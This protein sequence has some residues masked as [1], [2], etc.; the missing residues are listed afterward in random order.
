[1]TRGDRAA[2][3]ALP[4][5][6]APVLLGACSTEIDPSAST[7]GGGS[8]TSTTVFVAEGTTAE[9]LDQLLAD[10]SGLSERIVENEGDEALLARINTIWDAARPGVEA[11]APDLMLEFDR[12]MV[13]V[14]SAVERRR[15]ADADKALNNLRNLVAALPILD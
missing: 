7:L 9:L 4:L 11:A 13:M 10:L 5:L 1:V 15:H 8:T 12:A 6:V 2:L 3:A 14:N